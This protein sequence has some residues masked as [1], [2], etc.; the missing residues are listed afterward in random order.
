MNR[1]EKRRLQKQAA[2]TVS[3]G[4]I[5]QAFNE[6]VKLHQAG[7]IAGADKLYARVLEIDPDHVDALSNRGLTLVS[8]GRFEDAIPCIEKAISITPNAADLN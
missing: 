8:L 4:N 2:K 3:R 7:D 1:A 5:P 6:A